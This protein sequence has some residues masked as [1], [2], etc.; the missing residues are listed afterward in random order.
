M[1]ETATSQRATIVGRFAPGAR[2][3]RVEVG[4][5]ES[6]ERGD[7]SHSGSTI[8]DVAE[9]GTFALS[10]IAAGRHTVF[11]AWTDEDGAMVI[12]LQEIA[13]RPGE[14]HDL[15]EVEAMGDGSIDF[16]PSRL[17]VNS[18]PDVAFVSL[19]EGAIEGVVLESRLSWERDVSDEAWEA[20]ERSEQLF[21]TTIRYPASTGL[22]LRGL[23]P[24]IYGVGAA[25]P[26]LGAPITDEFDAY[27]TMKGS[28][29]RVGH[30]WRSRVDVDFGLESKGNVVGGFVVD[31][32]ERSQLADAS[33]QLVE[34]GGDRLVE[35]RSVV[36]W[37]FLGED[38]P[39]YGGFAAF[40]AP[41]GR[42][43]FVV[44]V[45]TRDPVGDNVVVLGGRDE[46][47]VG[48]RGRVRASKFLE[49][50]ASVSLALPSDGALST[51]HPF[52][53]PALEVDLTSRDADPGPGVLLH[54]LLPNT[55]YVLEPGGTRFTT[56]APGTTVEVTA[57]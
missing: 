25:C 36:P 24:G 7:E 4:N 35:P 21:G 28:S 26:I 30:S 39:S 22:R 56:G 2:D 43:A 47:R 48:K 17:L 15:G 1:N 57:H 40:D 51:L 18:L 13:L 52:D 16:T 5:F 34:V 27:R 37:L 6:S 8:V 53:L 11:C 12:A 19:P 14:R 10:G 31:V 9:D 41:P 46:V 32:G 23:A 42:W 50:T 38:A 54:G 49:P 20:Q 29:C 55:E 3:P 45:E 33:A 44:F